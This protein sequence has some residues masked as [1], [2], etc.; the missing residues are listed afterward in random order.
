MTPALVVGNW[1]MHGTQAEGLAL[2]R[3]LAAALGAQPPRATV[4]VAPPFTS[5]A[6]IGAALSATPILLAA[7]NCHWEESGAFTGEVSPLM[8]RD[9]GCRFVIVGHSERRHVFREDDHAVARKVSAA[10]RHGLRPILCVGETLAER[11]SR[12][13]FNVIARQLRAALKELDESAIR[14]IEIAYE[15]VWAIGTGQNATPEQIS[16]VHQRIR[17]LLA[18]RFGPHGGAAVRILYGGSVKPENAP[19]LAGAGDVNGF[20][21]GGASLKA[22][23]F[24]P[25]ARCF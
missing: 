11:R 22:E 5:L 24:V 21:V 19:E 14:Q 10:L 18:D 9:V 8:L 17:R 13:T 15:P 16:E 25:I 6:A 12:R 4:A 2:V 20:L 23:T 1:K 7:Q 3:N